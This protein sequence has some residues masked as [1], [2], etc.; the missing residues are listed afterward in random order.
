[1]AGKWWGNPISIPGIRKH[2]FEEGM[3]L[4]VHI[5]AGLKVKEATHRLGESYRL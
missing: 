2:W 1:M 3:I 5:T 4:D